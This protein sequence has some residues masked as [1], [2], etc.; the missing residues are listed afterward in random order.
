LGEGKCSQISSELS[1]LAKPLLAIPATP[2]SSGRIFSLLA[3]HV[4]SKDKNRTGREKVSKMIFVNLNL[5]NN[6]KKSRMTT[7]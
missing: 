1:Q 5:N 4:V 2:A 7:K 3:R 6:K